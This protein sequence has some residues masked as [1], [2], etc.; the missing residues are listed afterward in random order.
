[1]NFAITVAREA[2]LFLSLT[3][4]RLLV[5]SLS[6]PGLCNGGQVTLGQAAGARPGPVLVVRA[7]LHDE[8]LGPV[9]PPHLVLRRVALQQ[10]HARLRHVQRLRRSQTLQPLHARRKTVAK[11]LQGRR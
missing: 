11:I 4:I 3:S 9:Q 7:V 8:R 10:A 1:M 6:R 2:S 5:R